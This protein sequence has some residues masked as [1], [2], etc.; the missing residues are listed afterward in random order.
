[1]TITAQDRGR[2]L[3][4]RTVGVHRIIEAQVG[5]IEAEIETTEGIT[6][7]ISIETAIMITEIMDLE[8]IAE[9]A[10]AIRTGVDAIAI[11]QEGGLAKGLA[12][13]Q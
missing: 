2:T 13:S 10:I 6:I 8:A 11:D 7:P 3:D 12:E 4:D 5:V 9:E 1:M